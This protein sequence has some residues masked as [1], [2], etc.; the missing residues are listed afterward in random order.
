[1]FKKIL[2]LSTYILGVLSINCYTNN[3]VTNS[4]VLFN[5]KGQVY[6]L[7]NYDHPKNIKI[8]T[9]IGKD[10][11]NFVNS[12]TL[13]FHLSKSRF[14]TDLQKMLVGELKID[15]IP[16]TKTQPSTVKTETITEVNP[17]TKT[18]PTTE[19]DPTT[20]PDST[21]PVTKT[22]TIKTET[23][24]ESDSP[25]INNSFINKDNTVLTILSLLIT[26]FIF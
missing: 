12:D 7:S 11:E 22:T 23:N 15:C 9:I 1:M 17:T 19:T 4:N 16:T 6:D 3:D 26:Y 13:S 21:N 20:E 10:L 18:N 25:F 24:F 5:Y 2:L 8:D 14:Y